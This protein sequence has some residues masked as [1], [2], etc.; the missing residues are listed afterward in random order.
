VYGIVSYFGSIYSC[1]I[2]EVWAKEMAKK[3]SPC[4]SLRG[5]SRITC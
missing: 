3:T 1:H 2:S 4:F 5:G